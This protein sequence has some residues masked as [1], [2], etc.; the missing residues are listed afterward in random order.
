MKFY[1]SSQQL[2]IPDLKMFT[3]KLHT[4]LKRL[5]TDAIKEFVTEIAIRGA[6]RIHVDT[7]MSK[8]SIIP[9]AK[10]VRISGQVRAS[11]VPN[12]YKKIPPYYHFGSASPTGLKT[13]QA[14]ISLGSET[15]M[16]DFGTKMDPSTKFEFGIN[17]LQ[18]YL[19]EEG[20]G[21]GSKGAWNT[22]EHG[23]AAFEKYLN[24]HKDEII[25]DLA[26]W[27]TSGVRHG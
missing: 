18:Y 10:I 15:T 8:A 11:I 27:F 5:W 3:K 26:E 16:V 7:G 2:L 4:N 22:L 24:E 14:G 9:L 20:I 6:G 21:R 25:P 17:V 12:S 19:H 1:Y 13:I 23:Q